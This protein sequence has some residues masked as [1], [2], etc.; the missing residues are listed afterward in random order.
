MDNKF[1]GKTTD[2][3]ALMVFCNNL[4]LPREGEWVEVIGTPRG[5]EQISAIEVSLK[6]NLR[7][8]FYRDLCSSR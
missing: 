1:K 3:K 4:P 8:W 6:L 2:D 7:N 5:Q